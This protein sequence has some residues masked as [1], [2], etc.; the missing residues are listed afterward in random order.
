MIIYYRQNFSAA[1]TLKLETR[2]SRNIYCSVNFFG[3]ESESGNIY[4]S[5]NFSAAQNFQTQTLLRSD[6]RNSSDDRRHEVKF[7]SR[8]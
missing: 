4:S 2:G 7:A 1:Q 3:V 5:Q 8:N 6:F